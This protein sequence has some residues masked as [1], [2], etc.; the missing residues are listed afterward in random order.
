M[1]EQHGNPLN[2]APR[3]HLGQQHLTPAQE[4]EAR[5]FEEILH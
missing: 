5:R 2:P 4:A 3:L 1:N